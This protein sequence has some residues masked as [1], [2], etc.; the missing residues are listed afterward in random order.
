M[1]LIST[2][3]V[4]INQVHSY[5]DGLFKERYQIQRSIL[6]DSVRLIQ[7]YLKHF[8]EDLYV[9]VEYP[10]VDK[11]YRD[12]YYLYYSTKSQEHSRDCI[13]LSFFDKSLEI[14]DFD[15]P[16]SFDHIE[17]S[18]LGFIVSQTN[19]SADNR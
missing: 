5:L 4:T 1:K 15:D 14:S 3:I 17:T 8:R 9:L 10:Y 7:N 6:E 13:R 11:I 19:F 2:I 18:Y 12:S 16:N